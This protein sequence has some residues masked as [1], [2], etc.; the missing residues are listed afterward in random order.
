MASQGHIKIDRRILSWEWYKDSNMVHV[1]L[2]L[3]LNAN[4]TDSRFEGSLIK[5][6]QLVIGRL[7]LATALGLTERQIRTCL[8]KLKKTNEIAIKTTNRFSVVTI[9]KYDDYQSSSKKNDQQ[10]DQELD[11]QTTNKRPTNDQ[12][13]T[14]SKKDKEEKEI[15]KILY[16]DNISL[17]EKEN[18]SLISDYGDFF[19][20]QCYDLLSS[21]KMVN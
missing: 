20:N 4:Y 19:T 17:L 14:T 1:F 13:A 10:N 16:R 12:Q 5:R 3:L 11:Q 9:I 8:E 21:Y 18:N 6:G 2:H 7:K 15:K